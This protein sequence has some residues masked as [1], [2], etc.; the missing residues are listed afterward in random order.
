M[1]DVARKKLKR[2]GEFHTW[3]YFEL[4]KKN[5]KQKTTQNRSEE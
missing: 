2:N 4:K 1:D 3:D 5:P